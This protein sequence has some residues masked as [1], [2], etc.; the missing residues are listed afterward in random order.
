MMKLKNRYFRKT[1]GS[2]VVT[3]SCDALQYS[4]NLLIFK[5]HFMYPHLGQ[6]TVFCS[7]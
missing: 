2:H 3:I 4:R 1:S 5:V 6:K 7:G